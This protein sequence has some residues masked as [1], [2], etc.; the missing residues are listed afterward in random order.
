[1]QHALTRSYTLPAGTQATIEGKKVT[2]KKGAVSCARVIGV[3]GITLQ[4]NDGVITVSYEKGNKKQYKNLCSII[5]H[6]KSLAQGLDKKYEYKME[7]CNVHFPM[8]LKIDQGTLLIN[9]FLGEKNARRA[10]IEPGV[11]VVIQGQKLTITSNDREAAGM[12]VS[13]IERAT[14]V[15]KRDR[16]VFQDGIFLTERPGRAHE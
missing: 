6:V 1:M 2:L 9:N 11:E 10:V 15:R 12:T 13:N 7:A 3:D 5:A 8:T 14:H 16:R 4:N